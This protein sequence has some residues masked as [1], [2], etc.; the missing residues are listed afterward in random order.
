MTRIR[1]VERA[2]LESQQE[3]EAGEAMARVSMHA[4]ERL[5]VGALCGCALRRVLLWWWPGPIPHLAG[6]PGAELDR[7]R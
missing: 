2:E 6:C 1:H 4:V 5:T 7:G 3:R